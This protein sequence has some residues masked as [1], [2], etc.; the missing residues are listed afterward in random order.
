MRAAL[1]SCTSSTSL[2]AAQMPSPSGRWASVAG[3]RE[4]PLGE[5]LPSV[6]CAVSKDSLCLLRVVCEG[7]KVNHACLRARGTG[8][9]Q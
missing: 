3:E 7:T 2:K 4:E 5:T 9:K 6:S 8:D 1:P